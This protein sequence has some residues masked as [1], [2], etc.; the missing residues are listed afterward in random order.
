MSVESMSLV[1]NTS[2]SKGNDRLVLLGI[3]NHD[4]DGGAWPSLAT[5]ARYANISTRSVQRALRSLIDL[6]E[7]RVIVNGGGNRQ[8]DPR[9]RP[10]YY[11]IQLSPGATAVGVPE[12]NQG[13]TDS[14]VKGRQQLASEPSF[15]PSSSKSP[16]DLR[17][18][19]D[20]GAGISS[21][22]RR[23]AKV[24]TE[25]A[26]IAYEQATAGNYKIKDEAAY[27]SSKTAFALR[28]KS[29]DHYLERWPTA[30]PDAIA[31]WM[32]GYKHS[33]SYWPEIDP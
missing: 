5:L 7:L 2:R 19:R 27:R 15:E 30:P 4:G 6:G 29:I 11:V 17:A 24:A 1:L 31:A 3:A 32:H 33:M 23:R 26:R 22:D 20:Q 28:H 14:A 18:C 12:S 8:T 9:Y 13:V 16:T 25:Y 10:N 21:D